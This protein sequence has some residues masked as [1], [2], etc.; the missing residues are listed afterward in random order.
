MRGWP[1]VSVNYVEGGFAFST[2]RIFG[3]GSIR[4]TL[5]ANT[6]GNRAMTTNQTSTFIAN[7][8][9]A[10]E[11]TM[12]RWSRLLAPLLIRLGGLA[13]GDRVIDV[14]CGTGSLAFALPKSVRGQVLQHSIC[15]REPVW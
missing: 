6:D 5:A 8:A 3:A 1:T 4:A 2:L 15:L 10:Y 9:E 11:L 7:N 12:G 14:G 13:D